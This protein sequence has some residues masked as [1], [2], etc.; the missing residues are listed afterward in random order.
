MKKNEDEVLLL[1]LAHDKND[2]DEQDV[3]F[4]DTSASN[5]MCGKNKHVHGIR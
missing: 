1:L 2:F 3:W 5:H 4:L